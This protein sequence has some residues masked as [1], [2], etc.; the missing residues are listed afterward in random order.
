MPWLNIW[1]L[2]YFQDSQVIYAELDLPNAS[3]DGKILGEKS[4]VHYAYVGPNTTTPDEGHYY[5]T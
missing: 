1:T 2:G 3:Q 5:N 4:S